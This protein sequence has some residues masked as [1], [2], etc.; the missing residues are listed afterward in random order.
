MP[1]GY[2]S[3]PRVGTDGLV[4]DGAEEPERAGFSDIPRLIKTL[5]ERAIDLG[6]AR[7]QLAQLELKEEVRTRLRRAVLA[8]LFIGLLLVGFALLNVGLVSWLAESIGVAGASFILAGVYFLAGMIGFVWFRS[9]GGF[10]PP[11]KD[12]DDD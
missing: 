2:I 9:T 10:N 12:E 6:S 5:V 3:A 4:T 1:P 11:E 8:T 7:I